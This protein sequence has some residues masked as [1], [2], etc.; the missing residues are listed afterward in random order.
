MTDNFIFSF[1]DK[2]KT[3]DVKLSRNSTTKKPIK[4]SNVNV[5]GHYSYDK[6][7]Q[8]KDDSSEILFYKPLPDDAVRHLVEFDLS[9]GLDDFN[10]KEESDD[11]LVVS[12]MR[13]FL[14]WIVIHANENR[15]DPE[16]EKR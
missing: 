5:I 8:F 7:C 3:F 11:S 10:K 2:P 15:G 14:K 1:L 9:K 16:H 6:D 4:L 13:N 12:E